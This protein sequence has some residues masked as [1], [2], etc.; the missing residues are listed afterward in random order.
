MADKNGSE[1]NDALDEALDESFP[2]SD[3]PSHTAST[4]TKV[5]TTRA[6]DDDRGMTRRE[7]AAPLHNP[8]TKG[9]E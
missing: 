5:K 7:P 3:P 9:G 1:P 6:A 4:G 2:A 8:D